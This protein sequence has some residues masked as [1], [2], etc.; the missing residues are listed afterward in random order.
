MEPLSRHRRS[1]ATT[2]TREAGA[3]VTWIVVVGALQVPQGDLAELLGNDDLHV[4]DRV[5]FEDDVPA[6]VATHLASVVVVNADYMVSQVL[7][8]VTDLRARDRRVAVLMLVD[9]DKPGMLPTRRR[10]DGL[11]FLMRDAPP[12][13]LTATVRRLAGGE[14]VVQP[15]LEVAKLGERRLA[16][17][18]ELEVLGLAADGS[19]VAEI[20]GRLRLAP[21]TVRNYLSAVIAKTGARNR[22]DAIRIARRG[23]WLH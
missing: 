3:A 4:V 11:N 14:H 1:A 13:M 12:D 20:A 15:R 21:G 9:P 10:Y 18:R 16:S 5:D 8:L 17:T 22:I 6:V 19:T 2:Q 23:G 7:P